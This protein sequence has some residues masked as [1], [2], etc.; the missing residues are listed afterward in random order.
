MGKRA[1]KVLSE[2]EG[3]SAQQPTEKS[4]DA[5]IKILVEINQVYPELRDRLIDTP[6]WEG[7]SEI[8]REINRAALEDDFEGLDKALQAYKS[9]V[10]TVDH[11]EAQGNLFCYGE[12]G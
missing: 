1:K 6:Q 8:E 9:A 3:L 10:L 12:T 2:M 4:Q 11:G 5:I 7:L